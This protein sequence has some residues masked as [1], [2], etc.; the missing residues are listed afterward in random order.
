MAKNTYIEDIY[1]DFHEKLLGIYSTINPQD[2]SASN[3]FYNL[4]DSGGKITEAQSRYMLKLL[5]KYKNVMISNNFDYTEQ[6]S[7]PVWKHPFRVLDDTKRISVETDTNGAN[8]ICLKH[9]FALKDIFNKEVVN[10]DRN[11]TSVWDPEARVRRVP[12]HS[13][14]L[15]LLQD[16]ISKN[17]F[18]I[19]DSFLDYAANV[20]EIWQESEN[21]LPQCKI[22]N[23]EVVLVN[24]CESAENFFNKNKS[25]NINENLLLAKQLGYK[26][27]NLQNPENLVEKI[28]SK[29]ETKFWLKDIA[30][31]FDIYK[32]ISGQVCVIV[33]DNSDPKEWIEKFIITARENSVNSDEI[34]V[35]FRTRN[36]EDP[37]FNHWIKE[38]HLGGPVDNARLLI[39]KNKPPKW[40]IKDKVDVKIIVVNKPFP[41][42]SMISQTWISNHH[43]VIYLDKLRPSITKEK[44]IVDL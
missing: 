22:V 18:I 5:E 8:W 43:C 40:L 32:T 23:N 17:N 9:P 20:E 35:C 37:E 6:L 34:R 42:S 1:I 36:N 39:F 30:K 12:A 10:N 3:S 19:D 26:L 4:L 33:D 38:N 29:L 14:N 7:S 2:L 16:F 28:A 11:I 31:F 44:H 41:P 25:N 27:E 21:F 15:V 24:A 13:L